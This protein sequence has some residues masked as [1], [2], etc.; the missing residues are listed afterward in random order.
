MRQC[1]LGVGLAALAALA[2]LAWSASAH[3]ETGHIRVLT[4]NIAGLP[5]GFSTEHPSRN[6]GR[7][8]QLLAG[9]DI[10]LLQED[11]AY[12][13][14]LRQGV[15]FPFQSAP[16]AVAGRL[17]FGDGLSQ[18]AIQPFAPLERETWRTCHG[19]VGSYMDC[20]TPKGFTFT[21]QTLARGVQV[22]V[23]D[24][25][26][27]AGSSEGD[28]QAREAQ[29]VQLSEAI[30]KRSQ[31]AAVLLAGDTNLHWRERALLE[32]FEQQTGLVDACAALQCQDPHRIDKILFRGSATLTWVPRTW[33]LD[34][35]FVD[36]KGKPLS[37]H[38]AVAVELDWS[39][40]DKT[41][42]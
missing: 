35:R 17:D 37:D 23:Y 7:I 27:D 42:D 20:L 3:A 25:H 41:Q 9:N 33:G 16:F 2:A 8:G 39:S 11:F 29:L 12:A 18:F 15:T 30:A 32:R 24:L 13:A 22:D 4:Y 10:V 14:V 38:S 36:A 6:M 1:G 19:I 21:R 40:I 28:R 31:G 26:L 34:Q 5:D